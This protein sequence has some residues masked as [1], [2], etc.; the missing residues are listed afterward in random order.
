MNPWVAHI[1]AFA[2]KHDLAYGC[3]LSNPQC[4]ATYKSTKPTARQLLAD[5]EGIDRADV[6]PMLAD[7][8]KRLRRV[9]ADA[10]LAA[11]LRAFD[12]S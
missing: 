10:A 7:L 11:T 8:D 6:G 9:G 1:K 12:Y 3:A 5:V 2:K 4:R